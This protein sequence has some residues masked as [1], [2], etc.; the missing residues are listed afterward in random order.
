MPFDCLHCGAAAATAGRGRRRRCARLRK[1][2]CRHRLLNDCDGLR[3]RCLR[4]GGYAPLNGR[5][6]RVDGD[7]AIVYVR[8]QRESFA[9]QVVAQVWSGS[10]LAVNVSVRVDV[11]G[12][13]LLARM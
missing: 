11:V 8:H 5:F 12:T 3:D 9:R 1:R 4:A 6:E 7:V 10:P 2:R 13:M